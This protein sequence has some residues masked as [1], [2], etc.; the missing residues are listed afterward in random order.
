MP[1]AGQRTLLSDGQGEAVILL[2]ETSFAGTLMATTL[3]PEGTRRVWGGNDHRALLSAL[4]GVGP[5]GSR[6]PIHRRCGGDAMSMY[7]EY[8]ALKTILY[9]TLSCRCA[10]TSEVERGAVRRAAPSGG[11]RDRWRSSRTSRSPTV[12]KRASRS[13][14]CRFL[15]LRAR[16]PCRLYHHHDDACATLPAG[17]IGIA[18]CRGLIRSW[19]ITPPRT[20]WGTCCFP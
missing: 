12:M 16:G 20:W 17:T 7:I 13:T 2:D 4:Y 5:G 9:G 15:F 6:R 19:C 3:D 14:L 1:S 18:W 8:A 11:P 10:I